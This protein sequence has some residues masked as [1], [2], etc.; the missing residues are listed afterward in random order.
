MYILMFFLPFFEKKTPLWTSVCFP[1]EAA[2]E[3]IFS[4]G[5]NFLSVDSH[6]DGEGKKENGRVASPESVSIH[7]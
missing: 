3:R 5:A 1:L 6:L 7:L 2:L 4:L